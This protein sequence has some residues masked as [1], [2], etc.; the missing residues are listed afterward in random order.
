MRSTRLDKLQQPS[1]INEVRRHL[2]GPVHVDDVNEMLSGDG[3]KVNR[4]VI[5]VEIERCHIELETAQ[6]PH[7]H[8]YQGRIAALRDLLSP[9]FAELLREIGD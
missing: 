2:G 7:V 4:A 9:A 6:G 5:E 8:I 1:R 3:W